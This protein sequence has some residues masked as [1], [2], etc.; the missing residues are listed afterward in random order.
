MFVCSKEGSHPVM[1]W[2]LRHEGNPPKS[3]LWK[4][5]GREDALS[6]QWERPNRKEVPLLLGGRTKQEEDTTSTPN[7]TPTCA[8]TDISEQI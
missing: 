2:E 5:L 8:L 1:H 7:P 4:G 6:F 3:S